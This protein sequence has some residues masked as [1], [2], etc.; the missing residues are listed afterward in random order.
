MI[1]SR[2][3]FLLVSF[4][5]GQLGD[6]LNIFQGIYL[7][8]VGWAEGA[9]GTALSLM[10]LTSLV[11]QPFAGNWVDT[12]TIDRRWFLVLASVVTACSAS[13][14]L[15]VHPETLNHAL[16]YTSKVVEGIASSFI[17]PCL[18]ALTL[19]SFGPTKFDEVMA[20]NLY[21]GHVGSVAAAVL[22]GIVAVIGFPHVEYCFLVI[23]ASALVAIVFV[24]Y[25]PQGNPLLGRGLD[26]SITPSLHDSDSDT[27]IGSSISE[28]SDEYTIPTEAT[29]LATPP[30]AGEDNPEVASYW[31]VLSEYKTC[32]LCATGFFFHFA[33][34][35]VLLVL[36]EIM[37]QGG[38]KEEGITRFAIPLTAG[39]IVTAQ[40]IM[41][42]VTYVAGHYTEKG[43]GRK[44]LFLIGIASLPIRC[45][46]IILLKDAG[47]KYLLFT[48]VFDGI[49]GG[50]FGLIH[51]YIVADITFG[52]GRF[53]AV[54]GLTASAFGLGATLSNYLGQRVVENFGYV[55]SLSGS[56]LISLVPIIL[57]AM[58]M[59]ETMG[60]RGS[61]GKSISLDV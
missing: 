7:V 54:M 12:T 34:A 35:N 20:S 18:A 60:K 40:I 31:E 17:Q 14:I 55:I 24:P 8:G 21:W 29:P 59:P 30:S 1:S 38:E 44:P 45:A 15:F 56:F 4:S 11:M 52:T 48:Q 50:L 33:N 28:D 9:V 61:Q 41:A 43:W 2:L 6:G 36:G 58:Y 39:A 16:I 23:G 46:L 57:F 26:T 42:V 51:P 53:N 25:L 37:G 27:I 13:T 47:H 5:L 22:A 19:A 32:I 49:G 3:A 10:G